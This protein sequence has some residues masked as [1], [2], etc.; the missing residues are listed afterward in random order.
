[1]IFDLLLLI[2]CTGFMLIVRD[3]AKKGKVLYIRPMPAV[4][5]LPELVGR[6]EEMGKPIHFTSGQCGISGWSGATAPVLSGLLVLGEISRLSAITDT[7]VIATFAQPEL[8]PIAEEIMQS[9]AMKAGNETF[10]SDARYISTE[11]RSYISGAIG[12]I[13]REEVAGNVVLG[14][15]GEE[16]L[17]LLDA[18][19]SVG[20]M[21]I[22]GSASDSN[23]PWFVTACD[24]FVF[25]EE[26][27][28][29]AAYLEDDPTIKASVV[30]EDWVKL[31]LIGVL[32]LGSI[33][34]TFG[35]QLLSGI[36]G[37]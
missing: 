9:A 29:T 3:R 35:S 31:L 11:P 22:G 20:A 8:L 13:A 37:G 5:A 24:Y 26:I 27:L 12:I 4:L 21:Q 33:F 30:G 10:I 32:V 6:A 25:G 28:A 14:M 7:H 19:L 23:A 17:P 18:G 34:A 2:V 15:I 36:I 16:A 1:M